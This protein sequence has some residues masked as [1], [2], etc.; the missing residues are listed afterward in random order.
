[1]SVALVFLTPPVQPP[2]AVVLKGRALELGRHPDCAVRLAEPTVSSRHLTLRKRGQVYVMTDEGSQNGTL[3][4][5]A[6][7]EEP[8]LLGPSA[9][10]VIQDRDQ[11]HLGH[12][13][14][15]LRTQPPFF[16]EG[17]VELLP[18]PALIPERA[19]RAAM[20]SLSLS[21]SD[22]ELKQAVDSLLEAP[23]ERIVR[24]AFDAELAQ[25][26][27]AELLARDVVLRDPRPFDWVISLC[28][29]GLTSIAGAALYQLMTRN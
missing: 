17:E 11:I 12:V 25:R 23:E 15:E 21:V 19:V 18:D 7:S 24:P 13:V 14:I 9:P 20:E 2:L 27:R 22:E 4:L 26:A 1:M 28:A 6:G 3:V 29:L 5:A 16:A 8:V 10:R